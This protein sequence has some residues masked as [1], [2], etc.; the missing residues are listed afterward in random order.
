[1]VRIN[2]LPIRG[3]LRR[4]EL[5]QFIIVAGAALVCTVLVMGAAYLFMEWTLDNLRNS[6][7]KLKAKLADLKKQ[8]QA[9]EDLKTEITRLQKQVETIQTLTRTRVSPAP[10][11]GALS[12]A[13]P[14]D[15]WVNAVSKQGQSFSVDGLGGDNTVVVDFVHRLQTIRQGF[16]VRRPYIDKKNP[17][18]VPF[19]SEVKLMRIVAA[20]KPGGLEAVSFQITG[21]V[22]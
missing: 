16:T 19:F 5:K 2:L 1:M 21:M 12:L 20:T 6:E 4:R 17:D 11:L 18:D 14:D 3:I 22:R 15:I 13:M 10:F 9:I 7:T 8:N